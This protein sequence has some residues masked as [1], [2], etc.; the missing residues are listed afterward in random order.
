MDE[1]GDKYNLDKVARLP[2]ET[3]K[4]GTIVVSD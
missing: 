1:F 2:N 4:L 3:I